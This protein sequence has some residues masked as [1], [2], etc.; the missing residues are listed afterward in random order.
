M[1]IGALMPHVV[2]VPVWDDRSSA[3]ER[4]RMLRDITWRDMMEG[5]PGGEDIGHRPLRE[6]MPKCASRKKILKILK[7]P[8]LSHTVLQGRFEKLPWWELKSTLNKWFFY[9]QFRDKAPKPLLKMSVVLSLITCISLLFKP[10]LQDGV[11][12][13]SENYLNFQIW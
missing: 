5:C 9:P 2:G 3:P 13:F 8:D 4:E 1:G 11:L 7:K 6:P 12:C 10:S